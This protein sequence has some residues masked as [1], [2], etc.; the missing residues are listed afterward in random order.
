MEVSK[1]GVISIVFPKGIKNEYN[2]IGS[3]WSGNTLQI[4]INIRADLRNGVGATR[5]TIRVFADPI[6][7]TAT[8]K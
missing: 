4:P 3:T 1:S 5:R 8:S 7:V 2:F 6:N